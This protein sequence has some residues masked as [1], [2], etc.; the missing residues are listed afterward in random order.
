M[1]DTYREEQRGNCIILYGNVPLERYK[2]LAKAQPG[3][4]VTDYHVARLLGATI[5]MGPADE[6][7]AISLDPDVLAKA[8]ERSAAELAG[9]TLPDGALEWHATG[10]RE[11]SSDAIFYR[12]LGFRFGTLPMP[13]YIADLRCCRLL[14]EQ[15]P[16]FAAK[17]HDMAEVSGGWA[18]LVSRWSEIT[19]LMDDENPD[20]RTDLDNCPCIPGFKTNDPDKCPRTYDLLRNIRKGEPSSVMSGSRCA[21]SDDVSIDAG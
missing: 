8:R 7:M 5:A 14:L 16:A 10:R 1:S 11:T 21:E 20:W 9:V 12:L 17:F 13:T 3:D 18:E 2:A 19:A 4:S 6:I 15:V